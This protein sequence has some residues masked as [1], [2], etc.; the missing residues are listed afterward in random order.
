MEMSS[1]H[2]SLFYTK[3]V[4]T[5][6]SV[7]V[8][9]LTAGLAGLFVLSPALLL[10]VAI[11]DDDDEMLEHLGQM[12]Q[13]SLTLTFC[14][15]RDPPVISSRPQIQVSGHVEGLSQRGCHTRL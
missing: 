10:T 7:K 6:L 1:F 9:V 15:C 14:L 2:S 12:T 4:T 5:L 8:R 3:K 11:T 13:V